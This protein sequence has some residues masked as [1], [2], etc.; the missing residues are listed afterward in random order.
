MRVLNPFE[1]FNLKVSPKAVLES[2]SHEGSQLSREERLAIFAKFVLAGYNLL[3]LAQSYLAERGATR[4]DIRECEVA[5]TYAAL[6]TYLLQRAAVR[7]V[8]D[9][10]QSL[11]SLRPLIKQYGRKLPKGLKTS[12]EVLSQTIRIG[13]SIEE[14]VRS[15]LGLRDYYEPLALSGELNI[16]GPYD[17]DSA[18][19]GPISTSYGRWLGECAILRNCWLE[20]ERHIKDRV[21]LPLANV[22]SDAPMIIRGL[23]RLFPI[24]DGDKQNQDKLKERALAL[25]F[26]LASVLWFKVPL[27]DEPVYVFRMN[28]N[29]PKQALQIARLYEE[30][31]V[32]ICIQDY[33]KTGLD[34]YDQGY[35]NALE[36]DHRMK[37]PPGARYIRDFMNI[38][39]KVKEQDVLIV[40]SYKGI[41]GYRIG[42]LRKGTEVYIEQYDDYRLYC[43]K[44][45]DMICT[46]FEDVALEMVEAKDYPILK[47]IVPHGQTIS[48][49]VN[50]RRREAVYRVYYG[51]KYPDSY[52]LLSDD[53]TEEL[54]CLWLRSSLAPEE[55][56]IENPYSELGGMMK[57]ADI[58]GQNID[59]DIV[60]AQVTT[61]QD[62]GII[63]RK[64][65]SLTRAFARGKYVMFADY[66]TAYS[67]FRKTENLLEMSLEEV[68]LDLH[69]SGLCADILEQLYRVDYTRR[70]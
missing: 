66:N 60:L 38:V 22:S 68:W 16:G 55:Y 29:T 4:N 52:T 54:C 35:Y 8:K 58:I 9:K 13:I 27:F 31:V 25:A 61:S 43:L 42:K 62:L 65:K 70:G 34:Q 37:M 49:V 41:K 10:E 63:G 26:K 39:H 50:Q 5:C 57:N 18:Y 1:T 28:Y 33:E 59:G 40:A 36:A 45:T 67:P 12:A 20:V 3:D 6:A 23:A 46:P 53:A 7:I 51:A 56:R 48:H 19:T 15:H 32:A 47:S 14:M 17:Y 30:G 64:I 2:G 24:L 69:E 11:D 21:Y 44:M